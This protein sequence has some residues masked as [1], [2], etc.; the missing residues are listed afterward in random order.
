MEILHRET[1]VLRKDKGETIWE[2]GNLML[3]SVSEPLRHCT[4]MR[5]AK[6]LY[7]LSENGGGGGGSPGT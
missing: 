3:H 6:K 1:G 4:E 5:E 2:H 7:R